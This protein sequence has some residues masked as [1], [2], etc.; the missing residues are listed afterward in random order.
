MRTPRIPALAAL[1]LLGV[2][3]C[4]AVP[5]APRPA[6]APSPAPAPAGDR[7]PSPVAT[8]DRVV[9]PSAREALASTG[10]QD[11]AED[12][13]AERGGA[14]AQGQGGKPAVEPGGQAR[15]RRPGTGPARAVPARPERRAAPPER[16]PQRPA[17]R[18]RP[19]RP[20]TS[21]DMRSL[22]EASDGVTNSDVTALCRDSYGS[23]RR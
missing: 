16:R 21:Y 23:G 22:C 11:R 5:T 9:Q 4:V 1:V 8:P 10:P 6:T 19:P 18:P 7:S 3:G 20:R 13:A 2:T 12:R 17:S 14:K 15:K